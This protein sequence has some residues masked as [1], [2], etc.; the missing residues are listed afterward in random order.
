MSNQSV[1]SEVS[2]GAVGG[3]A[4]RRPKRRAIVLFFG[5]LALWLLLTGSL[6]FPQILSGTVAAGLLTAF[7]AGRMSGHPEGR[8]ADGLDLPV[9]ILQPRFLRYVLRMAV[10][11]IRA[12]W[13]VALIV[14]DPR[15]PVEP[16][17]VVVKTKLVHDLTRVI[18]ANSITL[19]PGTISVSL[20]GDT[21]TVHAINRRVAEG[22]A[23]WEIEDRVQE[24]E[25]PWVD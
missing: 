15:M 18:Y 25:R 10:E 20:E 4:R 16:H 8:R 11:I 19:T 3:L 12:N 9:L 6:R 14:L 22:V 1:T 24:L 23:D 7:W 21:L 5:L 13:A 2:G 17:F